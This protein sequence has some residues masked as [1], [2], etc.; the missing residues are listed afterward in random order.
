MIFVS[1]LLCQLPSQSCVVAGASVR[2][3]KSR[4]SREQRL[5]GRVAIQ[6]RAAKLFRD[7]NK[8]L[9]LFSEIWNPP[10]VRVLLFLE[11]M[12]TFSPSVNFS[13]VCRTDPVDI[14]PSVC[15]LKKKNSSNKQ[16]THPCAEA[17]WVPWV[18]WLACTVF[19]FQSLN[20]ASVEPLCFAPS[21]KFGRVFIAWVWQTVPAVRWIHACWAGTG[22]LWWG[23]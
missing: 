15:L 18:S 6:G 20:D 12:G 16:A 13:P 4:L 2:E 7:S 14:N 22:F 5:G 10:E 8:T 9:A 19:L 17:V 21:W 1:L 11:G 23:V 3:E